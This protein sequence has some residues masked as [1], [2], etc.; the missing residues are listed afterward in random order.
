MPHALEVRAVRAMISQEARRREEQAT[1]RAQASHSQA[2]AELEERRTS[3]ALA[4][5]EQAELAG[6]TVLV[7]V[8]RVEP[9]TVETLVTAVP[10]VQAS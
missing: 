3:L 5:E 9:L 10:V 7:V 6:P 8:A 2:L 1:R 4:R